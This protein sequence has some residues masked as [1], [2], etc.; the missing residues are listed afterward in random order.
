MSEKIPL[1]VLQ[2]NSSELV[3]LLAVGGEPLAKQGMHH[4][5]M[6][7]KLVWK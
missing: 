4:L 1:N 3:L 7:I 5:E 6:N 2:C